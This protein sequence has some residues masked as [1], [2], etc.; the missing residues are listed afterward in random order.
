[1]EV[2]FVVYRGT[3]PFPAGLLEGVVDPLAARLAPDLVLPRE[4]AA[5]DIVLLDQNP[6]IRQNPLG[7]GVWLIENEGGVFARYLRRNGSELYIANSLTLE[8]PDRWHAIE[9][10]R[11]I[12]DIVRARIVWIGREIS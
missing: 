9:P 5:N 12:L 4:L 6:V 8:H 3:M 2:T 1:M 11:N 7:S 10:W